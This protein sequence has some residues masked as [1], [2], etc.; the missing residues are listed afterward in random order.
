MHNDNSAPLHICPDCVNRVN[1]DPAPVPD[2]WEYG[3]GIARYGKITTTGARY[4]E[5][6]DSHTGGC[7]LCMEDHEDGLREVWAAPLTNTSTAPLTTHEDVPVADSPEDVTTRTIPLDG[8]TAIVEHVEDRVELTI[9]LH[10]RIVCGIALSRAEASA[11][12]MAVADAM[13]ADASTLAHAWGTT[14]AV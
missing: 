1:G 2:G 7:E 11:L 10:D 3:W 5:S 9:R 6:S 12:G 14:Q 4:V 8:G 13:H